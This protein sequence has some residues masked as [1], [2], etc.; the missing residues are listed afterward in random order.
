MAF[1]KTPLGQKI[2]SNNSAIA[3]ASMQDGE[4]WVKTY[5]RRSW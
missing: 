1:Y 2:I 3:Q 4:Q 5:S